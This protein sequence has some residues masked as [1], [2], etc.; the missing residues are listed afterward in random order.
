M[1]VTEITG[2]VIKVRGEAYL[3][4]H[5]TDAVGLVRRGD[6]VSHQTYNSAYSL[7]TESFVV[8]ITAEDGTVGWG[9]AQAPLV[10]EVVSELVQRLVGPFLLGQDVADTSVA[11]DSAYNA[12][13]ERGHTTGYQL[14]AIAACDIALWDL[15]GKLFGVPIST[16]IG[17]RFRDQVSCYVSGLPA[18]DDTA[19]AALALSW[20]AR[21]F[22]DFK[23]SLGAS[24][25]AD[26][27]SFTSLRQ[28]LGDEAG[29]CVDAHWRYNVSDAIRLGR[30][31]EPM[32]LGFLEAPIAPEDAEGQAEV[33]RAL[34]APVAIGEE[35]RTRYEFRDRLERRSAD[36]LQPDVGR[37]GITEAVAVGSLAKAFNIPIALHIG[38]GLGVYVSAGIQVAAAL[39][40]FVTMEYQPQQFAI[41]MKFL[42]EPL[43]CMAGTYDVPTGPGLGIHVA[44]EQIRA[45]ASSTFT[46][47]LDDC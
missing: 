4:G 27:R 5:T 37:M 41:A 13:R 40:N 36:I 10:P 9:E 3:G 19:R 24:V 32:G 7:N 30:K 12:M 14:D 34:D 35:L 25:E 42:E 22:N 23:V 33:A 31:L 2:Y 26:N 11:W 39:S 47:G 45:H 46:I 38:V 1:K 21:G 28:A 8:R 43:T 16:L 20:Q 15:K 18:A 6:Y 44:E 29:I 17:G